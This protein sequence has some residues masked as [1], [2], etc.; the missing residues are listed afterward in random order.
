MA[1]T[2]VEFENFTAFRSLKL[3]LC[4]G[5]NV[6]VGANGTGK[7]HLMRCATRRAMFRGGGGFSPASWFESF[8]PS[9]RN[10]GRLVRRQ[11]GAA[12]KSDDTSRARG[13]KVGLPRS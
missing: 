8:L 11:Q 6:L 13:P 7:T 9:G 5:I 4:P 3:D 2:R 1:L 12:W 10:L